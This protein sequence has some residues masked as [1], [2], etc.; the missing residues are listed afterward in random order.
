MVAITDWKGGAYNAKGL[1]VA[2]MLDGFYGGISLDPYRA[3]G[4]FG[5]EVSVDASASHAQRL[6]AR[7]GRSTVQ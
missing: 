2:K 6:L 3:H 4:A 7:L 1:D 5:P